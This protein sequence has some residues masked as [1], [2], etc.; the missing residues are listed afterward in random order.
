MP[1]MSGSTFSD[2]AS[3]HT[4]FGRKANGILG[5][6]RRRK[7]CSGSKT[8]VSEI[9]VPSNVGS[10]TEVRTQLNQSLRGRCGYFAYGS[11]YASDKVI[12]QHLYDRVRN[13]LARRHKV[14]TRGIRRIRA[15]YV[16]G[17]L[18]VLRPRFARPHALPS[19]C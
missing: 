2:T 9:L 15:D 12:E 17:E 16:F 1:G 13:F 11:L 8:K 18:G 19:A 10:W 5:P 7:A 6:F 4:A 3:A 14:P